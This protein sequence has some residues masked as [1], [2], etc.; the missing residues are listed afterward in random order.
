MPFT[1]DGITPDIIIN[2]HCIPTRMTIGHLFEMLGSK[3]AAMTG[4]IEDGTAFAHPTVHEL[5]E[6]MRAAGFNKWGDEQLIDGCTG[7]LMTNCNIFIAPCYYQKL[8][9]MV[10]DKIHCREKGGPK[11]MLNRQP[12]A[13]KLYSSPKG[14]CF[15]QT[16]FLTNIYVGRGNNGGH[17][18]G[19]MESVAIICAGASHVHKSLWSQSDPSEWKICKACGLYNAMNATTC[20]QCKDQRDTLEKVEIP[21]SWKLLQTELLACGIHFQDMNAAKDLSKTHLYNLNPTN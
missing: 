9:H 18:I 13:G 8:R 17:R 4:K 12:P 3:V 21:Y 5:G 15:L 2:P 6:K 11:S 14:L 16:V 7:E 20:I 10:A 1:P 19:E